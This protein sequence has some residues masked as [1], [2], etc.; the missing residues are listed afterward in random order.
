MV[1]RHT[2]ETVA[3]GGLRMACLWMCVLAL[4]CA[5]DIVQPIAFSHHI[6]T[7]DQEIACIDCHQYNETQEHSGMPTLEVCG[8]CHDEAQGEAPEEKKILAA[9][10][11]GI[12]PQWQRLFRMP[13]HVFYSHRRHVVLAKLACSECHG[14][15]GKSARP[16]AR[17][18]VALT[19][20][21]CIDCHERTGADTDCVACHR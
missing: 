7:V 5:D 15:M 3:I 16:P 12:E 8:E 21:F 2:N 13:D 11:D 10:K 4:G 17:P 14:T 1:D 6:H 9:V 19:M 18:P 20:S